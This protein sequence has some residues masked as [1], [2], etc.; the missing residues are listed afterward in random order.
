MKLKRIQ[1]KGFK[2]FTDRSEFEF[3]DGITAIVGPNG[4]GKSNL[5][6]AFKW[7]LGEQSAKSLRGDEMSDVIFRG[8]DT[9]KPAP[10]AEVSL[11]FEEAQNTLLDGR[12]ALKVTRRLYRTG[13]SL[14]LI[15]DAPTRL[16]DVREMFA[17]TGVGYNAYSILEQDKINRILSANAED[18]RLVFEEAAGVSRYRAKRSET[19][20][21]LEK[22]NQ[23]L[24]IIT[25]QRV[26]LQSRERGIR[27]QA[28]KARKYKEYAQQI[29]LLKSQ[30]YIRKFQELSRKVSAL[31]CDEQAKQKEM[32]E[33]DTSL[34]TLAAEI[35]TLEE[36]N[37]SLSEKLRTLYQ[38]KSSCEE[39][40]KSAQDKINYITQ[41]ISELKEKEESLRAESALA[42]EKTES[43]RA[44][45]NSLLSQIDRYTTAIAASET[46]LKSVRQKVYEVSVLIQEAQDLADKLRQEGI[47]LLENRANLRNHAAALSETIEKASLLKERKISERESLKEKISKLTESIAAVDGKMAELKTESDSLILQ[48]TQNESELAQTQS[49]I[50]SLR[51]SEN[52]LAVIRA[53]KKSRF[54]VVNSLLERN[55]G[56][57]AGTK[58]I[59]EKKGTEGFA[60]VKG[61]L[62]DL[63]EVDFSFAAAVDAAL[64]PLSG[65]IVV[66]TKLDALSLAAVLKEKNAGP[67]T[68]LFMDSCHPTATEASDAGLI[69]HIRFSPEYAGL[70]ESL[71]GQFH[72]VDSLAS[73]AQE[74]SQSGKFVTLGGELLSDPILRAGSPSQN[75]GLVYRK[76]ELSLLSCELTE[77]NRKMEELQKEISLKEQR[78]T[79]LKAICEITRQKTEDLRKRVD[80]NERQKTQLE[81]ELSAAESQISIAQSLIE[82]ALSSIDASTSRLQQVRVELET[83]EMRCSEVESALQSALAQAEHQRARKEEVME[84]LSATSAELAKQKQI[85]QTF[86]DSLSA[87][88]REIEERLARARALTREMEKAQNDQAQAAAQTEKEKLEIAALVKRIA[89]LTSQISLSEESREALSQQT[90]EKKSQQQKVKEMLN[91]VRDALNQIIIT[92][93]SAQT[94]SNSLTEYASRELSIN[95]SEHLNDQLPEDIDLAKTDTEIAELKKKMEHLGNVNMD[96]IN[97]L[98]EVSA[99]LQHISAQEK[100][101]IEAKEKLTNVMR[102]IDEKCRVRLLEVFQSIRQNFHEIFRRLFGGGRADILFEEGKDILEAGIEIVAKPPGKDLISINLLSGG[103]K[104]LTTIALLFAI[105]KANPSPFCILDEIDAPLDDANT[106]KFLSLVH[107]FLNQSQFLIITH[108]QQTMQAANILYGITMQEPCVSTKISYTLKEA[109]ACEEHTQKSEPAFAEV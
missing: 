43:A 58:F 79:E 71:L 40:V 62:A 25:A 66:S 38:E 88:R 45:E 21:E 67:V 80:S 19:E 75:P 17:G 7:V 33:L 98:E 48:L 91:P 2:A 15:D 4:A 78:E 50:A 85:H 49:E 65:A 61:L 93:T 30:L 72:L 63:L 101:L 32:L 102:R 87:K 20:R 29:T 3:H 70:F 28:G 16:K 24:E 11:F 13:E 57:D 64:G 81:T 92:K 41:R 100:D 27:V 37:F 76:S 22:T 34:S 105:F 55:E 97:E 103:E 74:S 95:L 39:K 18:R 23:N 51:S 12:S 54:E 104:A 52:S 84:E 5:V 8:T 109:A 42:N 10:F 86:T 89:D 14:Y 9:R 6:D 46:E 83:A 77:M 36:Q 106:E 90:V 59:L 31:Q 44:E 94:E 108:S 35:A 1:L 69:S 73:T 96:A 56:V 53:E 26:E 68:F 82:E 60:S 47:V 99:S 107:E